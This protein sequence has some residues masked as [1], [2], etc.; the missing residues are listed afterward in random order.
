MM[1]ESGYFNAYGNIVRK[2]NVDYIVH[3]G[4]Y[5]YKSADGVVGKDGMLPILSMSSFRCMT[6]VSV[7]DRYFVLLI[8]QVVWSLILMPSQY[9]TDV[10]L[11]N[12]H[13]NFPWFQVWDDHST[14]VTCKLR[15]EEI[16]MV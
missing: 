13:Q 16:L 12:S 14:S 1:A 5:I 4:D 15:C 6:T 2:D 7:S 11:M 10:D 3:L 9:H 8:S